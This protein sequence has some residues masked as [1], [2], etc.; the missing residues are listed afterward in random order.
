MMA[1]TMVGYPDEPSRKA[2]IVAG[3]ALALAGAYVVKRNREP[4][5]RVAASVA[6]TVLAKP[7]ALWLTQ[8]GIV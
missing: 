1:R 2:T 7:L 4:V 3:V 6:G 8:M 5:V